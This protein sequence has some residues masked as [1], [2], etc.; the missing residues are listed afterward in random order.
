MDERRAA[1]GL[2]LSSRNGYLSAKE[3]A[4]APR[5]YKILE[6]LAKTLVEGVDV[7]GRVVPLTEAFPCT[8]VEFPGP[9]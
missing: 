2:A 8:V 3:R 7:N 1:D 9:A 4:E 5:L 6:R